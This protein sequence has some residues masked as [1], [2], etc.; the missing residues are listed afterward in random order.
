VLP[1]VGSVVTA[2]SEGVD[3]PEPAAEPAGV[4]SRRLA[5][6]QL[7]TN[8]GEISADDRPPEVVTIGIECPV[9]DAVGAGATTL[10]AVDEEHRGEVELVF[11]AAGAACGT[12]AGAAAP[13]A[14]DDAAKAA[15]FFSRSRRSRRRCRHQCRRCR[16]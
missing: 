10:E 6:K 14:V 2:L 12:I 11:E 4:D 15:S 8:A 13:S 5:E 1:D 7:A 16:L 9:H 3:G